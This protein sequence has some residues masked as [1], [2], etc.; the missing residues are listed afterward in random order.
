MKW[1][2]ESSDLNDDD[3]NDDIESI[4]DTNRTEND[5]D[6]KFNYSNK[7]YYPTPQVVA[8]SSQ[9]SIYFF[10]IYIINIFIATTL[11]LVY[12]YIFCDWN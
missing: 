4:H 12:F 2:G 6:I 11:L 3:E 8:N 5:S 9:E 1:I 10:L 7:F